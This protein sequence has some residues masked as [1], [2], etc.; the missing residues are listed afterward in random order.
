[1]RCQQMCFSFRGECVSLVFSVWMCVSVPIICPSI[2]PS[3]RQ[4]VSLLMWLRLHVFIGGDHVE[5]S[6]CGKTT[7]CWKSHISPCWHL[8][9]QD[10]RAEREW[11]V[12]MWKKSKK[13]ILLFIKDALKW[14]KVTVKTFIMLQ[15]ISISNKC[16]SFELSIHLW[17]LKKL[18]VSRFPQ[19]YCA[20]QLFS[21]LIIIRNVSWAA[22]QYIIM[23]SEDH[24]TLK[25]GVMMLKIQLWSQK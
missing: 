24:V 15:K 9:Y 20:A 8:L 22:N 7:A 14:E 4:T 3:I 1:M 10:K 16:C 19:K 6:Y 23:I 25:T 2:H 17:I 11:A 21:T 5:K 18:N 13:L 12:K